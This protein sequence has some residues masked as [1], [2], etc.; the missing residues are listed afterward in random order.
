L[1][2]VKSC[3]KESSIEDANER[4]DEHILRCTQNGKD[5]LIIKAAEVLDGFQY[6][7]KENNKAELEYCQKNATAIFK[8][9]PGGVEDKVFDE[10]K[11]WLKK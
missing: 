2:L 1:D 4:I 8:Y 11:K 10:L 7:T 6:Y 9:M 3:T 5:A